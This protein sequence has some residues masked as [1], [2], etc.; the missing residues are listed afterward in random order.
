MNENL[1]QGSKQETERAIVT[2]ATSGIGRAIATR[3]AQRG[4]I[5]GVVGRNSQ[6]AESLKEEIEGNNGEAMVLLCDVGDVNQVEETVKKFVAA[7]GGIDTLVSSAGIARIGTAIDCTLEDWD[8]T[9]AANIN[10]TFY[11]AKYGMPEL[12]KTKGTFTAI[13]SDA[14]V[15]AS[16]NFSAYITSKYALNGFVKSLAL[17]YGKHGVRCNIICPGFVETPMA[18]QLLGDLPDDSV[19]FYRKSIPLGRFAAPGEV[20]EA[21]AFITSDAA[22]Y[23]NGIEF[24]LDGGSTAGDFTA[25][26]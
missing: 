12:L 19:E 20:A 13:G 1:T 23:I 26:E 17:D 6:A 21:V 22:D 24:R 25:P 11:L 5:V 18:D 10:G 9:M 14:S 2:G 3:L 8:E 15:R 16:C 4:A 7:Y